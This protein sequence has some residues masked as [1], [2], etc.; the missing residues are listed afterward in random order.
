MAK[1]RTV[2]HGSIVVETVGAECQTRDICTYIDKITQGT[3]LPAVS[4]YISNYNYTSVQDMRDNKG[5]LNKMPVIT[6]TFFW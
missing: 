2:D 6:F 4:T 3:Y 5:C 1:D